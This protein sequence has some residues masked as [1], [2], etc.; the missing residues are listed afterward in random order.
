MVA[1]RAALPRDW[2]RFDQPW[3]G[4]CAAPAGGLRRDA[5]LRLL[6][7]VHSIRWTT[8][9]PNGRNSGTSTLQA[10]VR[11]LGSVHRQSRRAGG[12]PRRQVRERAD[13]GPRAPS[14]L[15]GLP[16]Q[17]QRQG[18]L[19]PSGPMARWATGCEPWPRRRGRKGRVA[20]QRR[21][22]LGARR[23][24]GGTA[25]TRDGRDAWLPSADVAFNQVEGGA[26]FGLGARRRRRDLL[27]SGP[28]SPPTARL[29]HAA[30]V[31]CGAGPGP[32]RQWLD[33]ALRLWMASVSLDGFL[34]APR[35]DSGSARPC[36]RA[37]GPCCGPRSSTPPRSRRGGSPPPPWQR[38]ASPRHVRAGRCGAFRVAARRPT[39]TGSSPRGRNRS[40]ALY[41]MSCGVQLA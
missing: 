3:R 2:A 23:L 1:N 29:L 21:L 38:S 32:G 37:T 25:G 7:S 26:A 18:R 4:S 30:L 15:L 41:N 14:N 17:D 12:G 35:P 27:R 10:L 33:T 39:A 20:A 13:R 22:R 34:S 5:R 40:D 31:E 11:L 6:G 16:Q 9:P 28:A 36:G 24:A 19:R 8:P